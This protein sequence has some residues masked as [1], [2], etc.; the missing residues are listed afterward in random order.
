MRSG[1][2]PIYGLQSQG[3]DGRTPPLTR[4][5]DMAA[6]Y[7]R[8]I[9]EVLPDGPYLLA[10]TSFGG[11]LAYEIARQLAALGLLVGSVILFDAYHLHYAR[12]GAFQS[13]LRGYA[14]RLQ[15]HLDNLL[16]KANR[17]EY[18]QRRL[19]IACSRI[20]RIV[21]NRTWEVAR[22]YNLLSGRPLPPALHR[23]NDANHYAFHTYVP[24]PYNGHVILFRSTELSVGHSYDP[25]AAWRDLV[26]G[27]LD[28]LDVPGNHVH[29]RTA[30]SGSRR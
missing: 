11:V 4:V 26:K 29:A 23:V 19:A 1:A 20:R 21:R 3:L 9:C 2:Q 14:E 18:I 6:Q 13:K 24:Q 16:F 5:E 17:L 15:F 8:E 10:G 12:R 22:S 7:L 30:R 27:G 25:K 28:M